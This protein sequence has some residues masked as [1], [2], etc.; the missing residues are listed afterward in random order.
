MCSIFV[1]YLKYVEVPKIMYAST[2]VISLALAFIRDPV[3]GIDL[4]R[5]SVTDVVVFND[6]EVRYYLESFVDNRKLSHYSSHLFGKCR[7]KLLLVTRCS[8]IFGRSRSLHI[9]LEHVI[10]V[11]REA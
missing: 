11:L 6:G 10:F 7:N 4:F 5:V 1:K 8:Y 9:N 2:S 3:R